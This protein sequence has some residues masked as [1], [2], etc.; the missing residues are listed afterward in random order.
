M[1]VR[2]GLEAPGFGFEFS[3]LEFKF[4]DL[5]SAFSGLGL[6]IRVLRFVVPN[7]EFRV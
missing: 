2:G 5:E 4:L 7:F 6:I 3:D 1:P